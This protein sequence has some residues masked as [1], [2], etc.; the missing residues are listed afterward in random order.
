MSSNTRKNLQVAAGV[1][2]FP[3]T[4]ALWLQDI[5]AMRQRQ[6]AKSQDPRHSYAGGN[7]TS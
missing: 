1:L 6:R 5:L 2:L 4:V 7:W 3:V